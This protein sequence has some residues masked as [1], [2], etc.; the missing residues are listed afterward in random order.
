MAPPTFSGVTEF[1]SAI[2]GETWPAVPEAR[3]A[4]RLSVLLQLEKSQWW[5]AEVIATHQ[6]DQLQNLLV[7]AHATVPFY[8]ERLATTGWAPDGLITP[9]QWRRLPI[10]TRAELQEAE[11]DVRSTAIP[12]EHGTPV[13]YMTSGST[14]RPLETVGTALTRLMWSCFTLRHHLWHQQDMS[15]KM[16]VIRQFPSEDSLPRRGRVAPGWGPATEAVVQTGPCALLDIRRTVGEQAE[17]LIEQDPGYLLTYP[18]NALAL[19]RLFESGRKSL[20]ELRAVHTF[21]EVCD[22]DVRAEVRAAFGVP[23]V[24]MYSSQEVGYVALQCPTQ[25]RYHVQA[26][27]L[28]VEV[29]DAD[30]APCRPG[31]LGRVVVTTLHNFATPLFRYELGDYAQVG[32]P[33]P[34]GRGLPAL[35]RVLGRQRNMLTLPDGAQRW[36]TFGD[37]TEFV[38]ALSTLPRIEQ[39]Q[40]VQKS[41][42]QLEVLLV[43]ERALDLVEEE[44]VRDYLDGALGHRFETEFSYHG[45]IPRSP[46][47]KFEDFRSE[48]AAPT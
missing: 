29:L 11:H 43:C 46:S 34:C 48:L 17:W 23:V 36:P 30:G 13:S 2:P 3:A 32:R 38:Q 24:D 45:E 21:G 39:F 12:A 20:P 47:G 10:L 27:N 4:Q 9:E 16:A 42:A 26:E 8:K 19:A 1:Q 15:L 44:L 35:T 28:I 7:H 14:A 22:L 37:S 31:Q 6:F 25:D 18:S 5:P 40:V 41:L 33:C